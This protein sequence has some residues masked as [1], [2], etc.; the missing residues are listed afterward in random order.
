MNKIVAV[1]A[2]L[3]EAVAVGILIDALLTF[4]PDNL[5]KTILVVVL[6]V[7][8]MVGTAVIAIN[9]LQGGG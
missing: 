1:I 3:I 6:C 5:A 9:L 4:A 7:T 8:G 2:F